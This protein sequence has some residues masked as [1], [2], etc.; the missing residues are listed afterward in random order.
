MPFI[1]APTT[2]YLGKR[3]DPLKH[4]LTED[5]VYY[6]SRHLTTHAVVVGMTGSGK[7]GL[8]INLLEEAVIDNIPAIII[9]PKG[10][11]TNLLLTFPDLQPQDFYNWI[12][13]DDA[14]R[15][16]QTEEQYAAEIARRWRDGLQSWSIVPDRLKWLKLAAQY[17]IY[18]PGSDAGLPISILASLRAPREGFQVNEEGN[19]ER[20]LGTVTALLSLI[21]RNA[22]PTEDVEH[23]LL[24]NIFEY[25][26]RQGKDLSLE[27]VILQVQQ[28]P[29][30]KLGVF[31]VDQY[32]NEKKRYKLAMDL[33]NIVASPSFQ[34]WIRGE[35]L[36]IQTLMYQPNG[37]PRVSIFYIAHLSQQERMF[38]ITL[39]LENLLAWMRMQSGTTSLRAILYIDEMFGF[40]PSYPQNPPTKDPI[41]RLLKQAR[42]FGLGLILATQNPG[43]L[44]YKG[45]ANA[46]TWFIGRL[47]SE[48]DRKKVMSGLE[49]LASAS[50]TLDLADVERMIADIDPRVFLMHNVHN[51]DGPILFHTR[52]AMSYLRGPLTRQQVRILMEPQRQA[53]MNR[54]Q[55]PPPGGAYVQQPQQPQ[56]YPQ[57]QAYPQQPAGYPQAPAYPQQPQGY[58]QAPAYPPQPQGYP[59]QQTGYPPPPNMP[60]AYGSPN[61]PPPP[62]LPGY[63]TTQGYSQTP[64]PPPG[65]GQ[66]YPPQQP[67]AYG[68]PAPTFGAQSIPAA[69]QPQ[70]AP[71]G[72]TPSGFFESQPAIPSAITQY[73]L[74]NRITAN[75]AVSNWERQSNSSARQASV[76]RLAYRPMVI[77]QANVRYQDKKTSLYTARTYAFRLDDIASTGLVHWEQY[78]TEPFDTR[79]I[80]GQPQDGTAIFASVPAA[81]QEA[82]RL[83]TLQG[84]LVDMLYN[85]ARLELPFNPQLKL[86]AGPEEEFSAFQ[87]RVYQAA[88]EGRDAEVD[89]VTSKYEALM[90]KVEDRLKRKGRELKAEEKELQDRKREQLFTTG[91]AALSLLQGRT[92][93]TLSRVASSNRYRRQTD[94]DLGESKEVITELEREMQEIEQQFELELKGI[95]ERWAAVAN[96]VETYAVSP[97]K[98]D[99]HMELFGVAWV[100]YWMILLGGQPILINAV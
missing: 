94:E 1:E 7:T 73:F 97:L 89:K 67:P 45:L 64:P 48:N 79:Q 80:S 59:Q 17:S 16:G 11:I 43:D 30:E 60:P 55:Q 95:N 18:T 50:S 28:P 88:R 42:A 20:I 84:D 21:G 82:K 47:Q 33:N 14:Q 90:D 27:D 78:A 96:I 81:M 69:P 61:I 49:G 99:I 58:P 23:V 76:P 70:A 12:N 4:R 57:A 19:R 39:I 46:G 100:P 22:K 31:A 29:F 5:I 26:W 34:S 35:P 6:D 32:I 75:E 44:D 9:D 41:L 15:A 63:N 2:F 56:G 85:T 51:D 66:Q 3:Y 77:G 54:F 93:F 71:V 40:F 25:N 13:K 92:A 36:D 86:Y 72:N 98:K 83:T 53:L 87:A 65:Y 38:I 62:A 37:R 24:S 68:Q 52:W 91:E 8:C 10:D 74:P